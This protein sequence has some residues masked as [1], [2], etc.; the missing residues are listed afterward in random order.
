MQSL[1]T[2]DQVCIPVLAAANM[3]L[4]QCSLGKTLGH[5]SAAVRRP[6]T[7]VPDK[8]EELRIHFTIS[9]PNS[10]RYH[11]TVSSQANEVKCSC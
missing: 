7:V 10:S 3:I 1:F 2:N 6:R 11:L 5:L 9:L 8:Y 4:A